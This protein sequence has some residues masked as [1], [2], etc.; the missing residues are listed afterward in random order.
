MIIFMGIFCTL[1]KDAWKALLKEDQN[2]SGK[3]E[4]EDKKELI[5]IY[6][7]ILD[8]LMSV[9]TVWKGKSLNDGF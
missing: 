8:K 6:P 1:R 9:P 5:E 4:I 2:R 3:K 7:Q